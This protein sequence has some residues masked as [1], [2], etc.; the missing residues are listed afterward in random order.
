MEHA[1]ANRM[2]SW[3][4]SLGISGLVL[5]RPLPRRSFLRHSATAL[6]S[7]GGISCGSRCGKQ[8]ARG[9]LEVQLPVRTQPIAIPIYPLPQPLLSDKE[10][11]AVVQAAQPP[12]FLFAYPP[13]YVYHALR[14]WGKTAAFAKLPFANPAVRGR[15]GEIMFRM[16][17]EDRIYQEFSPAGRV[18]HLLKPTPFGVMVHCNIDGGWGTGFNST[19]PGK[20]LQVMADLDIA[21]DFHLLV[22]DGKPHTI[23]EVVRDEARRLTFQDELEWLAN[24]LGRYLEVPEWQNRFGEWVSFDRI[25]DHLTNLQFGQGACAGGHIPYAMAALV[26]IQSQSDILSKP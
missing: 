4:K 9:A 15:W 11:R 6:A 8:P 5:Q 12:T 1:E 21:S 13:G 2:L 16:L 22:Y 19:H 23:A 14:L 3:K 18:G 10:I 26:A 17:T 25:A 7:L 24:G 20:Y